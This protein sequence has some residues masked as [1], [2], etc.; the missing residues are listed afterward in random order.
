MAVISATAHF[1]NLAL[2]ISVSRKAPDGREKAKTPFSNPMPHARVARRVRS[3]VRQA[4][5]PE[6]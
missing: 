4:I 6:G 1:W 2:E 5:A 3:A